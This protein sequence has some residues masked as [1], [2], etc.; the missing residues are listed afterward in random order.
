[1]G[2]ERQLVSIHCESCGKKI[3]EVNIKDGVVSIKC[4]KCGHLNIHET[5]PS[6]PTTQRV[7]VVK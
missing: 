4:N 6:T 3:G 1:M 7:A 5:K 2:T